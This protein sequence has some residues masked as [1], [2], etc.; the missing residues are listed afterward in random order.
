ML[1]LFIKPGIHCLVIF[2]YINIKKRF[3]K[4]ALIVYI[5]PIR[6][7]HVIAQK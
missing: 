3:K 4:G 5:V 1:P 7:I 2:H 6:F